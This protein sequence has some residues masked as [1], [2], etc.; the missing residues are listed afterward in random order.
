MW[1]WSLTKSFNKALSSRYVDYSGIFIHYMPF[2]FGKLCC[3]SP[4]KFEKLPKRFANFLQVSHVFPN[5][6]FSATEKYFWRYWLRSTLRYECSNQVNELINVISRHD[7]WT[8][9]AQCFF[10]VLKHLRGTQPV[11]PLVGNVWEGYDSWHVV[12]SLNIYH[13]V[14]K[15]L[16]T[17]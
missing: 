1:T 3:K 10:C 14:F 2:K 11:L 16:C 15:C 4:I 6:L 8:R 17:E 13:F 7:L 9:D 12:N 5:L